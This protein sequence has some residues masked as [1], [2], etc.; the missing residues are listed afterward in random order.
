MCPYKKFTKRPYLWK[1]QIWILWAASWQNQQNDIAPS[2]GSDQP[3]H[4]PHLLRV[5]A[6][7]WVAKD[8]RSL[9]ADSEDWSDWADAQAY[10][11][12]RWAH[13]HFVGFVMSRLRFPSPVTVSKWRFSKLMARQTI[14]MTCGPS[15]DSDPP[16]HPSS[17]IRLF[18]VRLKKHWALD[19][20][21]AQ[22]EDIDQTG[23]LP[24]LI[25]V[26]A[27][28]TC[29]FVGFVMRRLSWYR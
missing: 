28:R 4:P 12:L 8:P 22:N 6:V 11:S 7:R 3:G 20:P 10:L 9:H 13:T 19:Y 2:E 18:A 29:H 25:W 5:F 1:L 16:G 15:E 17:L 27:A 24:R 23:R 21:W 26:F 14:K